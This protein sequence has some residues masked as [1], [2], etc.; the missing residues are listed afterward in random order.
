MKDAE[1]HDVDPIPLAVRAAY[2]KLPKDPGYGKDYQC[3]H[4]APDKITDMQCM[5]DSLMGAMYYHPTDQ[6]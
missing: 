4:S 3:P 5:Q 2:T 1:A 6:G